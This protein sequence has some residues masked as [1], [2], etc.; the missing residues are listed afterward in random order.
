[1]AWWESKAPR[2]T[3]EPRAE[4]KILLSSAYKSY[5]GRLVPEADRLTLKLPEGATWA[6]AIAAQTIRRAVGLVDK[7]H[8]CFTAITELREST[9]GKTP[10]RVIAAGNDELK[11]LAEAI[12]APIEAEVVRPGSSPQGEEL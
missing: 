9:E 8:I 3:R 7:E 4:G 6:D 1:M 12:S 5:L 10:E 11:A 2:G